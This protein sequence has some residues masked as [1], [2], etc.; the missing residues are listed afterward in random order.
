MP[1]KY[2]RISQ[3]WTCDTLICKERIHKTGSGSCEPL[4]FLIYYFSPYRFA[5]PQA[6]IEVRYAS[7][8]AYPIPLLQAIR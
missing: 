8:Y 1:W 2:L 7:M 3:R 5:Q 6:D 4:H